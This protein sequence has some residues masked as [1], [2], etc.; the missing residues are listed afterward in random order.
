[1]RMSK[2]T[3]YPV[4]SFY[5]RVLKVQNLWPKLGNK[6]SRKFYF[7]LYIKYLLATPLIFGMIARKIQIY[8]GKYP[9][10]VPEGSKCRNNGGFT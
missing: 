5:I 3:E 8:L 2:K 4:L 9:E 10:S 1:M 7:G 6:C